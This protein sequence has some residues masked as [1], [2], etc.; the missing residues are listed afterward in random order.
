MTV[1]T[2]KLKANPFLH[3]YRIIGKELLRHES[4]ASFETM[5]SFSVNESPAQFRQGV[6]FISTPVL[7]VYLDDLLDSKV[8]EEALFLSRSALN[9][10]VLTWSAALALSLT[11]AVFCLGALNLK[12]FFWI[13]LLS[14]TSFF[15]L[16]LVSIPFG[17]TRRLSFARLLSHEIDRRRGLGGGAIVARTEYTWKRASDF[18]ATAVAG[19]PEISS[20]PAAGLRNFH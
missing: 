4:A 6:A 1:V 17:A 14:S 16:L 10:R 13:G 5:A 12:P 8:H 2:Q 7:E 9:L 18:D 20:T 11:C 3:Q 15:A 19:W